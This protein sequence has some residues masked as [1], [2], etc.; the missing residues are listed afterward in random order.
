MKIQDLAIIFVIIIIP[1]SIVLSA[2]TQFQIETLNLQ[3]L[4]DTKLTTATY[5]AIKAFQI[6]TAN[7]TMSDLSNSKMRDIEA[8]ITTFKNSVMST[9][10]LNG[11]T[12]EELNNYIPALVYTMYDGFYVY[13]PYENTNYL[14]ETEIK[15]DGSVDY[16]YD[17]GNKIP[18][19]N[20]GET[21]YGL[22]PYITYSC[23]YDNGSNIDVVITYSLDNFITIQGTI[24][25]QY[26]NDEGYLI[27]GIT[28]DASGNI[29]YNGVTISVE[30]ELKE[31]VGARE[32][33]YIKLNGTKYYYSYDRTGGIN[34]DEIFYIS[35]GQ[36]TIQGDYK[37]DKATQYYNDVIKNNSSAIKYYTK[38]YE[39]SKRVKSY[40]L[41][42]LTYDD[43][44]EM[45]LN[46]GTYQKTKIWSGDTRKIFEFNTDLSKP[47]KNIECELSNYNQHRLAVIRHKIEQNLSIAIANYNK[48][49][50]ATGIQ[51]QMPELKEEE[52]NLVMNNIS[53][54]SFVQGLYIG[55]KIY[56]GYSIVNNSESKEVVQEENIYI[57]GT[58]SLGN[59]VYYRIGD[60]NL[61]TESN[62]KTTI[63]AG[64]LNLDFKRNSLIDT[65]T[66][67][68]TLY[69]YPLRNFNAS[70]SSIV[71]QNDVTTYDDIYKY[72]SEQNNTVK[73]AFYQ[74]LGREREGSYSFS[75]DSA[76][77]YNVLVVGNATATSNQETA[78]RNITN[79]LNEE[80]GINATY[81]Y[82]ADKTYLANYIRSQKNNYKLIIV[83]SFV[84]TAALDTTVLEEI[85]T[86]T[87]I[88]TIGNDTVNLPM[89]ESSTQIRTNSV[90]SPQITTYG[91][92]K[93]GAGA[94]I[95]SHSD[96]N[97]VAI[98]FKSGVNVL[99]KAKYS[100]GATGQWDAIGY[101]KYKNHNWIHSQISFDYNNANEMAV[102]KQ[103]V[104]YA[105]NGI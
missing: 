60:N 25:G 23:R 53:L 40:G 89:I 105:M 88:L 2:Y 97:Q 81:I 38:A 92:Q 8:S 95:S 80:D 101:W 15:A 36:I 20:N 61:A 49:S 7:S 83:D 85:A 100:V 57:L 31:Y 65:T 50:E 45:K 104:K 4:Y 9:F 37:G 17:N 5:D 11:Y 28:K 21:M 102:L 70:Y 43:A 78:L 6:N 55:G 47:S 1:I 19:Y 10:G 27:D 52:W 14:Y 69:Y 54:I 34:N 32:Y 73:K 84:W 29:S 64:R 76:F 90:M 96:N 79:K 41:N 99:C 71:T 103:L 59:N 82:S 56:N 94:S 93:L 18:A 75:N 63:P 39:F 35:N 68:R 13:S 22:K 24:N 62:I 91:R 67:T 33:P 46:G 51:F 58:D 87:N 16:K 26:I 30:T 3:T 77:D 48:Y 66:N 74:A 72:V 42:N 44:W 86:A 98:K 12:E